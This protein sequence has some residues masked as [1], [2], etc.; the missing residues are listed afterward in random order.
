MSEF[1]ANLSAFLAFEST[2]DAAAIHSIAGV[3]M[4]REA[5]AS[6]W[7][8]TIRLLHLNLSSA[9]AFPASLALRGK[10]PAEKRRSWIRSQVTSERHTHPHLAAAQYSHEL[11]REYPAALKMRDQLSIWLDTFRLDNLRY[12]HSVMRELLVA[13][14]S[15]KRTSFLFLEDIASI[16]ASTEAVRMNYRVRNNLLHTHVNP[17]EFTLEVFEVDKLRLLLRLLPGGVLATN[18]RVDTPYY[19]LLDRGFTPYR[20]TRSLL[21]QL[22]AAAGRPGRR[23][24]AREYYSG[25]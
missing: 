11:I 9:L 4:P 19:N 5:T 1:E 18:D 25:S 20:C 8:P 6:F 13:L 2:I 7:L 17:S 23:A 14:Y 15:R 16:E 12:I 24:W 3:M 21:L 22:L 10:P